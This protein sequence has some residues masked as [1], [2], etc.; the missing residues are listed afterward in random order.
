MTQ[1]HVIRPA[2]GGGYNSID[3]ENNLRTAVHMARYWVRQGEDPETIRLAKGVNGEPLEFVTYYNDPET[4][5]DVYVD[6][7]RTARGA[8][9]A[10][11]N[12]GRK[13]PEVF[14]YG[15]QKVGHI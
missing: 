1:W 3:Y 8:R 7:Y 2:D 12:V 11:R 9:V 15:F 5:A 4:H 13:H 14:E 6:A 10:M